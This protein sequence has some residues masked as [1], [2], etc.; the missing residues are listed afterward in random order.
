MDSAVS[1]VA[2][3]Q[4]SSLKVQAALFKKGKESDQAISEKLLE[5]VA[6][7]PTPDGKGSRVNVRA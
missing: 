6:E 7:S 2:G 1:E 5:S 4:G 3:S